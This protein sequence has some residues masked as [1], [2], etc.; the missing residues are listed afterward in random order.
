MDRRRG[1]ATG[2]GTVIFESWGAT[3]EEVS[4]SM[5]GDD[6]VAGARLVATRSITLGT[7]PGDVF[8]W[9]RQMGFGRAG[10]YSY[11]LLDNF[12]RRS[13]QRIHDEWQTLSTG[14]SVPGGPI[15]FLA[16]AVEPPRHLVL[17]FGPTADKQRRVDFTLAYDLRNDPAGTRLVT[18]MRA[19]IDAPGGRLAE[20]LV[21]GP[22][23]GL[24]LRRQLLGLVSR[25]ERRLS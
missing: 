25:C 9:L 15:D 17:R 3:S 21:L 8:P 10:W 11:D 18:R 12:G 16:V 5:P 1:S 24:M 19:R 23:D 2:C 20:R 22:G 13:A 7:P 14:D 4:S 6:I